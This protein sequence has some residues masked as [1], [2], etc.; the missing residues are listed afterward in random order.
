MIAEISSGHRISKTF[1]QVA[2]QLTGRGEPKK[3]KGSLLSPLI[4]KL[5]ARG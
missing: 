1:L 3:P 2:N 5:R 4:S